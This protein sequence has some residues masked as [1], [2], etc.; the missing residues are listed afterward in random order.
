[1]GENAAAQ[2]YSMILEIIPAN[3]VTPFLEGNSLQIIF[4]AIC[5][6]LVLLVLGEKTSALR[7]LL[8]QVNEA[9]QF[10]MQFLPPF[11][12]TLDDL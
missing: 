7:L 4:M 6:G 3:I 10:M 11:G 8:G 2:I 9:V 12:M 5:V 1:M